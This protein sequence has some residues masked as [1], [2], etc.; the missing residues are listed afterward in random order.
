MVTFLVWNGDDGGV[1]GRWSV[2]ARDKKLWKAVA[3]GFWQHLGRALSDAKAPPADELGPA[4]PP[5]H[6]DAGDPLDEPIV[7]DSDFMHSRAP[8]LR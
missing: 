7:S 8:I 5:L 3:K 4:P 2:A 1:V 6:I